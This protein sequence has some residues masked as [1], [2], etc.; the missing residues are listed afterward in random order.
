MTQDLIFHHIGVAT[1]DLNATAQIYVAAGY[2]KSE[3]F[4]DTIQ[5]TNICFLTKDG[6]PRIELIEPMNELSSVNKLLKKNRNICPYH[7]CYETQD[8]EKSFEIM[9][10]EQGYIPLFRPVPATAFENRLICY[11][12]HQNVGY[13]EL[14]E[15]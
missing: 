4:A 12:F 1:S 11:L 6:Q 3:V 7:L 10:T 9:T 13:V 5:K 8:I 14:L 2:T 15:K